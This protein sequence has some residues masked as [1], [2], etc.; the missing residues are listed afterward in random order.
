MA[1]RYFNWKLA[2]VLVIGFVVLAA[3][4][5]GLRQWRRSGRAGRGLEVG[6]K[7]YNERRWEDAAKNL[8]LYLAIERDDVPVLLKYA[9]AGRCNW[10]RQHQRKPTVC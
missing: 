1:R 3:T 5:F 8:G 9:D 6:I 10:T 2:I 4:A 7:A